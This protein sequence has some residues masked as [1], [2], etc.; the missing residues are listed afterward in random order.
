MADFQAVLDAVMKFAADSPDFTHPEDEREEIDPPMSTFGK[1]LATV[2][3]Q[4]HTALFAEG[5]KTFVA[6]PKITACKTW[7]R[8]A[9]VA[10]DNQRS[11]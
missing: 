10:F 5:I 3:K 6:S 2:S 4:F 7:L 9:R 1:K 8:L 11:K